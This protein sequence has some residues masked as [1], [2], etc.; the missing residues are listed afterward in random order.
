MRVPKKL[1]VAGHTYKVQW[2][3]DRLVQMDWRGDCHHGTHVMS[4][5]KK[6]GDGTIANPSNIE[7]TFIHEMIHCVDAQYNNH[8]LTEEQVVRLG[9]GFHQV[10]KDLKWLPK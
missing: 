1:K 2:D 7:E 6:C 8:Q 3:T 9:T 4:L 5:A 10:L